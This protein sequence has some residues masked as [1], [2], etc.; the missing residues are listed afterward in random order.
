MKQ[1]IQ[2]AEKKETSKFIE[3][4]DY[5]FDNGFMVLTAYFL[6]KRGY[7]CSNGCRHCPYS[8]VEKLNSK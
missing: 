1:E 3:D 7:C 8:K 2:K 5:Y 4:V 6:L